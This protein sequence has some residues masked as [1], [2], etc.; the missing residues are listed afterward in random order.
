MKILKYIDT[1]RQINGKVEKKCNRCLNWFPCSE[2]YFYKN[3]LNKVDKLYPYCKECN[4]KKSGEWRVENKDR[5]NEST[6]KYRRT[7]KGRKIQSTHGR[8]Q[9]EEGYTKEYQKNNLDKIRGY[10]KERSN[11][12]HRIYEK[13]W[14]ACKLY[15]NFECAYCG[16]T[17]KEHNILFKQQLHKEHVIFNGEDDLSNCVPSCRSCNSQKWEFTLD[18]FYNTENRNYTELRYNKILKWLHGDYKPFMIIK[19]ERKLKVKKDNINF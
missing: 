18:E 9:R 3:N 17:E 13:E 1:Y 6:K 8:K 15:F 5:H 11:K 14:L 19:K 2:E 10:N 12:N 4:V 16:I 7:S